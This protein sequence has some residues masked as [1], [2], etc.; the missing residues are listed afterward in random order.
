MKAIILAAGRG[1]RLGFHTEYCP[2]GFVLLDGIPLIQRQ[3]KT[4][5]LAGISDIAVVTGYRSAAFAELE[6]T[7]FHNPRWSETNMVYSLMQASE[8]LEQE[9]CLVT[10]ADILYESTLV[11]RL[12]HTQEPLVL[13]INTRWRRLWEARFEHPLEDLESLRMASSGQLIDIGQKV[14]DI[15]TVEGQFMGIVSIQACAWK[16]ILGCL[17]GLPQ[18][19]LKTLDM[20]GLLQSLIQKGIV[21]QTLKTD[22]AWLEVD[23]AEDLKLYQDWVHS[24]QLKEL[25]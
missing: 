12:S 15:N 19:R 17:R 13:P 2:K 4:L 25:L 16:K 5:K 11:Q 18:E 1:S 3:I 21:I 10:Y 14:Y 22:S 24:G 9:H 8:W 7:A 6:L 23:D 20:T